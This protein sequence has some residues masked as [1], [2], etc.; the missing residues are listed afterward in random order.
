MKRIILLFIILFAAKSYAQDQLTFVDP[1][2]EKGYYITKVGD[3]YWFSDNLNIP[4]VNSECYD[5]VNENCQ[6]YGQLYTYTEAK[7]ACPAGWHLPTTEDW[8][9]LKKAYGTKA[10]AI[11]QP[12]VWKG[13][14]FKTADNESGL[15]VFPSGYKKGSFRGL[16]EEARFWIQEE[17]YFWKVANGKNELEQI[18]SDEDVKMPVRCV[19]GQ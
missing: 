11:A 9:S 15:S 3:T 19:F 13:N 5:G 7:S 6:K 14:K 4:T 10:K 17:G 2:D 16:W 8:N 1:R 12:N 18:N